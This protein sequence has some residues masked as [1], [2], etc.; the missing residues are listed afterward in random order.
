MWKTNQNRDIY[1]IGWEYYVKYIESGQA[2]GPYAKFF[3]EYVIANLYT[4]LCSPG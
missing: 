2:S 3:Q 4:T 1:N